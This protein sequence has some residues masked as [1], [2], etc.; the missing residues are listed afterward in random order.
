MEKFRLNTMYSMRL[1]QLSTPFVQKSMMDPNTQMRVLTDP[2]LNMSYRRQ[3]E[4]YQ[5]N[6]FTEAL[7]R[8]EGAAI[9]AA[10]GA[11][12]GST[13]GA[14]TGFIIGTVGTL[15]SLAVPG[16]FGTI[17]SM[18][19]AAGA[20]MAKAGAATGAK[21]GA[22]VG[23]AGGAV[24]SDYTTHHALMDTINTTIIDSFRQ[25][26]ALGVLNTLSFAG[27]SMDLI[28]GGEA[29][30]ATISAAITGDNMFENIS[31]AYG[32]HE[33]G[34][35]E[36]DFSV[37]REQMGLDL[38]AVGNFV[39][40][41]TGEILT[42][43][44]AWGGITGK[45]LTKGKA[46]KEVAESIEVVNKSMKVVTKEAIS[47][48]KLFKQLAR[49]FRHGDTEE[50][51]SALTKTV[52]KRM[53]KKLNKEYLEKFIKSV[54]EDA[55]KK[56][57]YNLY[58]MFNQID[59][60]DDFLTAKIFRGLPTPIG[61]WHSAK[62]YSKYVND[63]WLYKLFKDSPKTAKVIE[64]VSS[65]VFG[66][67]SRVKFI[68]EVTA[69]L[70]EYISF[71]HNLGKYHD[72]EGTIRA[73][74]EGLD[75]DV[76]TKQKYKNYLRKNPD[77]D[78]ED[79]AFTDIK[80]GYIKY[81]DETI[82]KL[83]KQQSD[84]ALKIIELKMESIKLQKKMEKL[85]GGKQFKEQITDEAK[86]E[87]YKKLHK[88]KQELGQK[89]KQLAKD[90][91][92]I[93]WKKRSLNRTPADKQFYRI[94][95][96]LKKLAALQKDIREIPSN[97]KATKDL[98]D[99]LVDLL[100]KSDGEQYLD[101]IYLANR[102][103]P[104]FLDFLRKNI[105]DTTSKIL[106]EAYQ[107][108]LQKYNDDFVKFSPEYRKNILKGEIERIT[109]IDQSNLPE[110]GKE[111]YTALI[112]Y[113]EDDLDYKSKKLSKLMQQR[114][115]ILYK[116]E[117]INKL[118]SREDVP[119]VFKTLNNT[120]SKL[121][122]EI[123]IEL[124]RIN[125]PELFEEAMR[126]INNFKNDYLFDK[127]SDEDFIVK[128]DIV[129][130]TEEIMKEEEK[131]L[132][133]EGRLAAA[134]TNAK[135]EDPTTFGYYPIKYRDSIARLSVDYTDYFNKT[136]D[137]LNELYIDTKDVEVLQAINTLKSIHSSYIKVDSSIS[138][139]YKVIDFI[140]KQVFNNSKLLNKYKDKPKLAAR[141]KNLLFRLQTIELADGSKK[142][143]VDNFPDELLFSK[144]S[145]DR[146][147]EAINKYQQSKGNK[148]D[149]SGILNE[150]KELKT[151]ASDVEYG[152]TFSDHT[153]PILFRHKIKS[154]QEYKQYILND[155]IKP[156]NVSKI[157]QVKSI[158]EDMEMLL[159]NAQ[160]SL[161]YITD[162]KL[163]KEF[164]EFIDS[165]KHNIETWKKLDYN[166]IV[167]SKINGKPFVTNLQDKL[168]EYKFLQ[169]KYAIWSMENNLNKTIVNYSDIVSNQREGLKSL[170]YKL[171]SIIKEK[172]EVLYAQ[173]QKHLDK[174][175]DPRDILEI[176]DK[177]QKSLPGQKL[178]YLNDIKEELN[179]FKFAES[180]YNNTLDLLRQLE[181]SQF[182]LVRMKTL[183]EKA[184]IKFNI[185][186][187]QLAYGFIEDIVYRSGNSLSVLL[188]QLERQEIDVGVL[189]QKIFNLRSLYDTMNV[190]R[191]VDSFSDEVIY[192]VNGIFKFFDENTKTTT[193]FKE[194][195]RQ[196]LTK[197][198][199]GIKRI[200]NIGKANSILK[201][202]LGLDFSYDLLYKTQVPAI[203]KRLLDSLF[204]N[205]D[206][207]VGVLNLN[208]FLDMPS[209]DDIKKV[210]DEMDKLNLDTENVATL[211]KLL[212]ENKGKD[213]KD[214]VI[215]CFYGQDYTAK[216][217]EKAIL[218][219]LRQSDKLSK[220][221]WAKKSI[222]DF[223][224]VIFDTETANK[225]HGILS[226]SYRIISFDENG[227]L[228]QGE[229]K[230]MYLNP[231]EL[232]SK[233]DNK[234]WSEPH[235]EVDQLNY[236]ILDKETRGQAHHG[237]TKTL[238]KKNI[239]RQKGVSYSLQ[240]MFDEI[241]RL[242]DDDNTIG[243]AHNASFDIKQ[244]LNAKFELDNGKNFFID[245]HMFN[246]YD[247]LD[248]LFK[249][250]GVNWTIMDTLGIVDKYNI[251]ETN[252]L[253]NIGLGK[254]SLRTKVIL[255]DRNGNEI[256][257]RVFGDLN[258]K[259][260]IT[261]IYRVGAEGSEVL[262]NGQPIHLA[263][264]DTELMEA[265]TEKALSHLFEAGVNIGEA[266]EHNYSPYEFID[267]LLK[268][269]SADIDTKDLKKQISKL[270]NNISNKVD[271]LRQK[272]S[273]S[274]IAFYEKTFTEYIDLIDEYFD[275]I[276]HMD[277]DQDGYIHINYINVLGELV[278]EIV[279]Q[280]S[281]NQRLSTLRNKLSDSLQLIR[282]NDLIDEKNLSEKKYIPGNPSK[283]LFELDMSALD[284]AEEVLK[285]F[286]T[287]YNEL[288]SFVDELN[289]SKKELRNLQHQ[290][291]QTDNNLS[292]R[293]RS[294]VEYLL[295][296][297][298][299]FENE[300]G[301][302]FIDDI[303]TR[304]SK[305][306]SREDVMAKK[307]SLVGKHP[308]TGKE[309]RASKDTITKAGFEYDY[310][311]MVGLI[312]ELSN[313]NEYLNDSE[314]Q[315]LID[316]FD[317]LEKQWHAHNLKNTAMLS[318]NKEI[319]YK[320]VNTAM[321]NLK[322]MNSF[323]YNLDYKKLDD[324]FSGVL[325]G[326]ESKVILTLKYMFNPDLIEDETIRAQI[327]EFS[328]SPEVQQLKTAW[329]N[330]RDNI[331]W[332]QDEII[333]K[334]ESKGSKYKN[335]FGI[336]NQIIN[337]IDRKVKDTAEKVGLTTP[338]DK[339]SQ[340]LKEE[341]IT[342]IEREA[343][344]IIGFYQGVDGVLWSD[345]YGIYNSMISRAQD[346]VSKGRKPY[347]S[348][349][350]QFTND[351]F[352]LIEEGIIRPIKNL[353]GSMKT[354]AIEGE[355]EAGFLKVGGKR[356]SDEV[357]DLEGLLAGTLKPIRDVLSE[358]KRQNRIFRNQP[359]HL[360]DISGKLLM[361][362]ESETNDKLY[363]TMRPFELPLYSKNTIV[364]ENHRNT[365]FAHEYTLR[366]SMRRKAKSNEFHQ[367]Y[368]KPMDPYEDTGAI[369][370]FE[371]SRSAQFLN[372]IADAVGID[373]DYLLNNAQFL[374]MDTKAE[375]SAFNK[376]F[377]D[378][379]VNGDLELLFSKKYLDALGE[380]RIFKL[381]QIAIEILNINESDYKYFDP[382]KLDALKNA[383]T[384]LIIDNMVSK[385]NFNYNST[386]TAYNRAIKEIDA[387]SEV[388]KQIQKFYTNAD[389]SIDVEGIQ[390]YFA[391][392]K[393]ERLVF[394]DNKTGQ[395]KMLNTDS[396]GTLKQVLETD[397]LD[398][399]V[400]SYDSFSKYASEFQRRELKNPALKWMRDVILR[401][402]KLVSLTF[403]VPFIVT[404]ALAAAVQD[405]T[406]TEGT[407]GVVPFVKNFT[408]SIK[409]YRLW[410]KPYE[411]IGSSYVSF[412]YRKMHPE[413]KDWADY[414]ADANFEEYLKQISADPTAFPTLI[415]N[416]S[417]TTLKEEADMILALLK[418]YSKEDKAIIKE[419]N[420][421]MR[422]ASVS[423]LSAE[424]NNRE[425]IYDA[426]KEN[427]KNLRTMVEDGDMRYYIYNTEP[428]KPDALKAMGAKDAPKFD[429][430]DEEYTWL[431]KQNK[432]S[433]DLIHRKNQL[434]KTID[435]RRSERAAAW[436]DKTKLP[437]M[438]L[439]FN[440]DM[441]TVFRTTMIKSLMDE[442][443][444][445]D[446]AA[447][448]TIRRHFLYTDK[449]QAE[450][451]AEFIIPFISYPLRSLNLFDE[452]TEDSS[453][454]KMVYLYDKYSWGD[455]E[456]QRKRS[457]YLTSR[458]A[459]GDIPVGDSLLKLTNPYTEAMML[460]SDPVSSFKNKMNP[461]LRTL[462]GVAPVTQLPGVSQAANLVQGINDMSTG[463]YTLGQITGMA[464]SFYR[465]SQ[466]FYS[467][468]PFTTKVKPF[469]SN[470]YTSGG[471]SRIAMNMQPATLKNVQYRVG[472]ILYK[473]S[474][475]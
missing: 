200:F 71:K 390:K 24:A 5:Q 114:D 87:S 136:M 364:Y 6:I 241:N 54:Q 319:V 125:K 148:I 17:A 156:N 340:E 344:T 362:V 426:Q 217:G 383:Y 137:T 456:E 2:L 424:F 296:H 359:L 112:K 449:S 61:V 369:A 238:H 106:K 307:G 150:L 281:P 463:N 59:Q 404:N 138:K 62:K 51:M 402:L 96:D 161:K 16:D 286:N 282:S 313:L 213:F 321:V 266:T 244:L 248:D 288:Q 207:R 464:N 308:I 445:L 195:F 145:I 474:I 366:D 310:A 236:K 201:V 83:D 133:K 198:L 377:L 437:K 197:E 219:H 81:R 121:D 33:E 80:E 141:L 104:T 385:D 34:R 85:K 278:D 414:F 177:Y 202:Q 443:A 399:G 103:Q 280:N 273:E 297:A 240:E 388:W 49:A 19:I 269:N 376:E 365:S 353:E 180:N 303:L 171:N 15:V 183:A 261:E 468:Q 347:L 63:N 284:G 53:T 430:I 26:P 337:T 76:E 36:Y 374:N 210:L 264:V 425:R 351:F 159:T 174:N 12:I 467:K 64:D 147:I 389:G 135:I 262:F 206:G 439:D 84:N 375:F 72:T 86:R 132:Y 302:V 189:S 305:L 40:D 58:G 290:L 158:F 74:I 322:L 454:M 429:S 265:W 432:L 441:E 226:L 352:H 160:D 250:V 469:Y 395:L 73:Y 139:V 356:Y 243:L 233:I 94:M 394:I 82:S 205:I 209:T 92:T 110:S 452:L 9:G 170:A 428:N 343:Q 157:N 300:Q 406:S 185:S 184:E 270:E 268:K 235:D 212:V 246:T 298:S 203:Y 167:D 230:I 218:K 20:K 334:L 211:R 382:N 247:N 411:V 287:E 323:Q 421:Y 253:T 403:S 397:R 44:G 70:R 77:V 289:V 391:K 232:Q 267:N 22:A 129:K 294:K 119:N 27:K 56:V 113:L 13:I 316:E 191:G 328:K 41:M 398:V 154:V 90:E 68:D 360:R 151:K 224:Y 199:S 292:N 431:S 249:T 95:R 108:S 400:M 381:R 102:S 196:F 450:Q 401:N 329:G 143:T 186:S 420:N 436:V 405:I 317:L 182:N 225:H 142:L 124:D 11:G 371:S 274:N 350:A 358:T 55:S 223:R 23:A 451:M 52:D 146:Y 354:V 25:N 258:S 327:E 338:M 348:P 239:E 416:K 69:P 7:G 472:N 131:L 277:A 470:L 117:N 473:R 410:K 152:D 345:I 475:M 453:F 109:L 427:L 341:L 368:M 349:N 379:I 43:P 65:F 78:I 442:G 190:F 181:S 155:L 408:K 433:G 260:E 396:L 242:L 18:S 342:E 10:G 304:I 251:F 169:T 162:T 252:T 312:E 459:K 1:N 115:E 208:G 39:F 407:V 179:A 116:L 413:Y 283:E 462:T 93:I 105:D 444:S 120:L 166:N 434:R 21:I 460:A 372:K 324:I 245:E 355:S 465:N 446:E 423:G 276:S 30:R 333:N 325:R 254:D 172:D 48:T 79:S 295:D 457:D 275:I 38:G 91:Q 149:Y 8:V 216:L 263:E 140:G 204:K 221:D 306:V 188:Q 88:Q 419:F 57:A 417:A 67:R 393:H 98:I 60:V 153:L 100:N 271:K 118:Y 42:D 176:I 455:A 412:A 339:W 165:F 384:R 438:F 47:N 215:N 363:R 320:Q 37:L 330:I 367:P 50:I 311:N 144:K 101:E 301:H 409:E 35:T 194:E 222:K 229:K 314:L 380:E 448:E 257:T 234:I 31:K 123:D 357:Q 111:A 318:R 461:V 255:Q 163:S 193:Q 272:V 97:K 387:T 89:L 392:N 279:Y 361:E 75:I 173:I 336:I 46:T 259:Y 418:K 331:N 466:Y 227:K 440:G 14:I 99:E 107:D 127:L 28:M 122:K 178:A 237:A 293:I 128:N 4:D 447:S 291:K 168:N 471:F 3:F 373:V 126:K 309:F 415:A 134:F 220:V 346:M 175:N 231:E 299:D 66:N 164:S 458:K 370:S 45:L 29:I 130:A 256:S 335:H 192:R 187:K 422:T 435:Q 386:I 228:V 214:V 32:T 315:N 378:V 332:Y 285:E 326:D